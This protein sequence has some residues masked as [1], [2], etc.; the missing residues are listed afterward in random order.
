MEHIIFISLSKYSSEVREIFLKHNLNP[1][2][3]KLLPKLF[4]SKKNIHH[5][6]NVTESEQIFYDKLESI[7]SYKG[8]N[9]IHNIYSLFIKYFTQPQLLK[10]CQEF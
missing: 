4:T 10:S 7:L 9:T 6:S 3:N 5:Y 2:K 1:Y 8:K